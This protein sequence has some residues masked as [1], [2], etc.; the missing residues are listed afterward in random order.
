MKRLMTFIAAILLTTVA[1]M[2]QHEEGD[3]TVQPKV[4]LNIATLS[5]ADKAI[6]DLHFG[7]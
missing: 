5:D 3:F 4:G 7:I 1:A 6:T 2:A